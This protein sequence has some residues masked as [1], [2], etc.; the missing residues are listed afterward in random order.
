MQSVRFWAEGGGGRWSVREY[1]RI[2]PLRASLGHFRVPLAINVLLCGVVGRVV[3]WRVSCGVFAV[4]FQII[5]RYSQ[6]SHVKK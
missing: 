3:E 5:I 6:K 4:P 1:Q 2:R